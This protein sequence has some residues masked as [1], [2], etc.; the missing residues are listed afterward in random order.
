MSVSTTPPGWAEILLRVF[1]APAD[2]D[3]VS[4]DLLEQYRESVHPARGRRR[5]DLWYV[6]QVF[7]FVWRN[8]R[9][10]AALFAVAFL[11]R[12]ALDW[13]VPPVDFHG[14][15]NVSTLLGAGIILLAGFWA[16]SRSGSFAAG[17]IVGIATAAFAAPIEVLGAATLLAG[18]HDP[19]T[20]AA[21]R[22]SGGLEEVFTLPL[23]MVLPGIVL[24][25][26]GGLVGAAVTRLNRTW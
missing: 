2:T 11:V 5:A 8:A 13:L 10:W 1:L 26:I 22:G 25:T 17:P 3:S 6:R 19:L 24:G 4:G 23:L 20:M 21:I 7:G 15:A 18:W 16:A 12:T 14:R 9:L